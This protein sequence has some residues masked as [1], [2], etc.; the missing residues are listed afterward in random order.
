MQKTAIRL[1]IDF[2]LTNFAIFIFSIID[3]DREP[4]KLLNVLNT[5]WKKHF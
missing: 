5:C 3:N 4:V 2:G 1:S